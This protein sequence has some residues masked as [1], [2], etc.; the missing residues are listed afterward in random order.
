MAYGGVRPGPTPEASVSVVS[1]GLPDRDFQ[2]HLVFARLSRLPDLCYPPIM[3]ESIYMQRDV[4]PGPASVL[5]PVT[6]TVCK[7]C[8]I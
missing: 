4:Q 6:L 8:L 7:V 1:T 2:V 5:S 3:T